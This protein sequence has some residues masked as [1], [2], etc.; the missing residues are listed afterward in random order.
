MLFPIAGKK[1]KEVAAKIGPLLRHNS[2]RLLAVPRFR[3]LIVCRG[4]ACRE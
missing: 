3:D 1:A 2:E 4:Q